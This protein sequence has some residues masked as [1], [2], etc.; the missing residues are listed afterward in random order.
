M[1]KEYA[2]KFYNS[3]QWKDC[4]LSFIDNRV[5]IDG[6]MCEVCGKRLGYIVHHISEINPN[7]IDNA[8]ITL[9]HNNLMWVCKK[10][11]DDIHYKE[12]YGIEKK[13]ERY[14]FNDKG[15]IEPL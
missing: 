14:L 2:R 3:K 15:E 4:R 9:N 8:N 12:I 5:S 10:C 11:H 6:G 1:A 7:N 13:E